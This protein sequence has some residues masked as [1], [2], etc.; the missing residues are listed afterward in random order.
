MRKLLALMLLATIA[1][2]STA[3]VSAHV[4]V[5]DDSGSKGAIL[6]IIP[7]DDPVAGEEARLYFDS[8]DQLGDAQISLTVQNP[9]GTLM[10][11]EGK[12]EGTLALFTYIFPTQGLYTL[13]FV[14][15]EQSSSFSYTHAQR[16][17]RGGAINGT[18][19]DRSHAWAEM[20]LLASG[21]G[22]VII[23]IVVFNRRKEIS[24]QSIH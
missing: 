13:N 21:L 20:L 19:D 4:L 5:S 10:S 24:K 11:L 15:T 1:F 2:G 9:D 16:V 23:A 22:L 7:D 6:H 8:Q 17:S 14:V 18:F 12:T 3:E